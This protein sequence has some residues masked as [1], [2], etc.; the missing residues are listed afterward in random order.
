[1]SLA[2]YPKDT[3][4]NPYY[5][6]AVD[7]CLIYANGATDIG[8]TGGGVIIGRPGPPD[9]FRP[10]PGASPRDQKQEPMLIRFEDCRRVWITG[11]RI[12]NCGAWSVHL[13]HSEDVFLDHVRIENDRRDG[14]DIEGCTN[15][16]ISN[17][18]LDCGDDAIALMTSRRDRPLRNLT[19]TNCL[20]KSKWAGIRLGPLS[21]GNFE[22]ITVSNCVIHD[23]DGG[24]I[25][26]G[27]F[28]GAEIRDC[29]FSNLVMDQVTAP[30]S[31]F[32]AT[33]PDIGSTQP[34]PPMMPPGRI[35]NLQ[36]R[37]IRAVTKLVRPGPRPDWN[38]GMFFHGYRGKPIENITLS[39]LHITFAGGGSAAD[40]RRRKIIDMHEID[41]RKGGYWTDNKNLW[42]IPPAYGLYARHIN[43]LSL[44]RV[45][46]ELAGEDFRSA[47]VC[48]DSEN[49][50]I[51]RF[52]AACNANGE[53]M[54]T[55]LNCSDVTLSE[56][57]PEGKAS[58][59]IRVEGERTNSVMLFGNDTRRFAKAFECAAGATSAAVVDRD[60]Q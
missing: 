14:F 1:M 31:L 34:N 55:T 23:C 45:R 57:R 48:F 47:V 29:I 8:V 51:S 12:G 5:P 9:G 60:H 40:G 6:E 36:F 49:L 4:L 52:Q 18:H 26:I 33:W 41:Y 43:G 22:N 19:V 44:D 11:I 50:S 35:R 56:C 7:P 42:G 28:E 38:T 53:A 59:L 10:A 30:I 16:S 15:I 2:D 37:G 46:F 32:I 17:C 27:M 25:K 3:G 13:K 21:K 54:I 20:L 24:G 58:A 39:D